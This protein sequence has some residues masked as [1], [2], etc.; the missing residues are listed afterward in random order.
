MD[1]QKDVYTQMKVDL[2]GPKKT[3]NS[4]REAKPHEKYDKQVFWQKT[5][6]AEQPLCKIGDLI[7][8]KCMVCI[9][10]VSHLIQIIFPGEQCSSLRSEGSTTGSML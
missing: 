5:I 7:C 10:R 6:L 3:C 2:L 9:E 8:L 1:I 4:F